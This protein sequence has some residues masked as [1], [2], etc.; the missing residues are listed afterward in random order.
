MKNQIT[1]PHPI[2]LQEKLARLGW[3][4]WYPTPDVSDEDKVLYA[5]LGERHIPVIN[6]DEALTLSDEELQSRIEDAIGMT[7]YEA[8][9]RYGIDIAER[10]DGVLYPSQVEGEAGV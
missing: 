10:P 7:F 6:I 5:S 1:C 2:A 3:V 9:E 8:S 4:G